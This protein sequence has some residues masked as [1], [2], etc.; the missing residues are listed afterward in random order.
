M[1]DESMDRT[2]P[3]YRRRAKRA[4]AVL[5]TLLLGMGA[6]VFAVSWS[7][8]SGQPAVLDPNLVVTE[9]RALRFERT[10]DDTLL[11]YDAS[12]D[13]LLRRAAPGKASFIRGTLRV[14]TRERQVRGVDGDAPVLL[15]AREDGAVVLRDT[16]SG[17]DY[18]LRAFGQTNLEAFA[19]LLASNGPGAGGVT[20]SDTPYAVTIADSH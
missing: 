6:L 11:I 4:R 10:L 17:V 7:T 16:A 2:S 1:N 12:S 5:M 3:D 13:E 8:R 14:I 9:S 15:Q 18:D 19:S 20:D